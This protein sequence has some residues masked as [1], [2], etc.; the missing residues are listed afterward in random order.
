MLQ[1]GLRSSH[2]T[3]CTQLRKKMSLKWHDYGYSIVQ[4][5]AYTAMYIVLPGFL[6][7]N[8]LWYVVASQLELRCAALCRTCAHLEE[9]DCAIVIPVT[10]VL[11]CPSVVL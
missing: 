8:A 5:L 1:D 2:M 7:C 3:V 10:H 6:H 11:N 9:K 4:A